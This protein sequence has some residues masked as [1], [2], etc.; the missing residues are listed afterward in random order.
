MELTK[1]QQQFNKM[2]K[3]PIPRLVTSL[4]VPTIISMLVTAIYNLADTFFVA[5]LGTSAAGAVGIVFSLMS[6]IQAVGLTLGMGAGNVAAYLLGRK[7]YKAATSTGATGFYAAILFGL[8][9]T[10]FGLLFLDPLMHALGSTPTILPYA[11]D[12]AQYILLGAPVMCASFVLNNL[13]RSEGKAAFAMVGISFGGVLNILL[14][15]YFIFTLGLGISGAA[16]A[17]LISQCISFLILLSCYL[18]KK[19]IIRLHIRHLSK[20]LKTYTKILKTGFPSLCRHGLASA[21]TVALNV[22]A[23]SYGD[24]AVAAMS[25]VGRIFMMVIAIMIGFGQGYTPV[26]G[27]NYGAENYSRVKRAMFF[28]LKTG[29]ILMSCLAVAG[30]FLAPQLMAIF[31]RDDAAVISIGTTAIRAQCLTLPLFPISTITN[32]TLQV[33][34]RSRQATLTASYR[35][36]IFFFPLIFLLPLFFGILGI[37]IAQPLSDF[38]SSLACLPFLIPLVR[39]LNSKIQNCA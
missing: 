30:F 23:A 17:T 37:Q 13:L 6:I 20:H 38:L 35:Q 8:I 31:R 27:Y 32:M 11:R 12:Y 14:D 18:F 33:L 2:T 26:V 3:T 22:S 1:E 28:A 15:P 7:E 29:I 19:T 39:E 25:V 34:G 9:L 16:I 10:I 24:E 21:A 4:A 5:Q 36:G